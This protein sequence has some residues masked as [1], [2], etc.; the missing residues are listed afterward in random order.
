M[1]YEICL[2][3][4]T[5]CW[6]GWED[7]RQNPPKPGNASHLY[8]HF[9][10]SCIFRETCSLKQNFVWTLGSPFYKIWPSRLRLQASVLRF[11]LLPP[12][13]HELNSHKLIPSSPH[14]TYFSKCHLHHYLQ[15][16]DI[17]QSSLTCHSDCINTKI[18]HNLS[19]RATSSRE[20]KASSSPVIQG[21]GRS[22]KA[23]VWRKYYSKILR[24]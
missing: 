21:C 15:P 20:C 10:K 1:C 16:S 22:V 23:D 6:E 9:Q 13:C 12:L 14:V 17:F 8:S 4:L 2:H 24:G 3:Q 5:L 18:S 7:F 19:R 11:S